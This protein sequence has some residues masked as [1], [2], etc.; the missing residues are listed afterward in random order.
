MVLCGRDL[1]AVR[2]PAISRLVPN[3]CDPYPPGTRSRLLD[4]PR[5]VRGPMAGR[6]A[7]RVTAWGT[8]IAVPAWKVA[9]SVMCGARTVGREL[10][11]Q[12]T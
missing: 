5:G 12:G 7:R 10:N 6:F 2:R 8:A 3:Y 9:R 1:S 4:L 11:N